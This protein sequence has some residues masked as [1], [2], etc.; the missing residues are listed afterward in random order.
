LASA[1]GA[2]EEDPNIMLFPMFLFQ[3]YS[4][5]R[6]GKTLGA[7]TAVIDEQGRVLLIKASYVKGWQLP[8]GGVD[9]GETLR[10]AA[11]R[12]LKEEACVEPLDGLQLHGIFSND[13]SFRGD[14]VA[15]Y[16]C[17]KYTQGAFTPNW[18]ITAAQFFAVDALPED[19]NRGARLRIMEIISGGGT[20]TDHWET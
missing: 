15:V 8:G 2:L 9:G 7:R 20:S 10:E 5:F 6:R 16:V 12:E 19:L 13:R 11:I 1:K 14:H 17:R 18:E 4:R 3:I